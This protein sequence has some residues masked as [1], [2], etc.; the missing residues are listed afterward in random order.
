MN[1]K[2][3][4]K[5]ISWDIQ[6]KE[7]TDDLEKLKAITEI[8]NLI[9]QYLSKQDLK[10]LLKSVGFSFKPNLDIRTLP[11]NIIMNVELEQQN[12]HSEIS[13]RVGVNPPPT[14]PPPPAFR[15]HLSIRNI[16]NVLSGSEIL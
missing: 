1:Q 10:G 2:K 16:H 3:N 9:L 5:W 6:F 14:P 8:Q 13:A 12:L 7:N 4:E 11:I 15:H